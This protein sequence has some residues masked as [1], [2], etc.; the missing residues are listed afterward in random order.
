MPLR[1]DAWG[2]GITPILT[3]PHR[4]GKGFWGGGWVPACAGTRGANQAASAQRGVGP[5]L[6]VD[7]RVRLEGDEILRLRFA[8]VGMTCGECCAALRMECVGCAARRMKCGG[9]Q[10]QGIASMGRCV[11]QANHPHPFDKLRAGSS[12]PP[13][14]G[15]GFWVRRDGDEIL[16]LRFAA[17]RMTCW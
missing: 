15:K 12:I 6:H 5:C 13:S 3:F 9:G 11:G 1:G 16:R 7:K 14:K 4:R 2:R 17:L 10:P 8:P